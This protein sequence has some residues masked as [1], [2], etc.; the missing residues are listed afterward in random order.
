M[1]TLITERRHRLHEVWSL[2]PWPRDHSRHADNVYGQVLSTYAV[3]MKERVYCWLSRQINP[4][5][6]LPVRRRGI[7]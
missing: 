7:G 1:E 5:L 3:I 2:H 4:G 6:S